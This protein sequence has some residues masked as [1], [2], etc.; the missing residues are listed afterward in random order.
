MSLGGLLRCVHQ[1]TALPVEWGR[2]PQLLSRRGKCNQS[3]YRSCGSRFSAASAEP[4][5]SA[6]SLRSYAHSFGRKSSP[7]DGEAVPTPAARSA[8][9]LT[10]PA[11]GPLPWRVR[12]LHPPCVPGV[13]RKWQ[14]GCVARQR[15]DR[16]QSTPGSVRW[17]RQS[18]RAT[19]IG[20]Q[21]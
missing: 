18:G 4:C 14:V 7:G 9:N 16:R 1:L 19:S 13:H 5:T 15:S 8:A 11:T 21:H 3:Q 6:I 10:L 17:R 2:C 20:F 12:R